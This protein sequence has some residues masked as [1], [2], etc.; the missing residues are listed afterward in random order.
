MYLSFP[1]SLR[2]RARQH[3]LRAKWHAENGDLD[4]AAG[5]LAKA[6]RWYAES[7]VFR[8]PRLRTGVAP[9]VE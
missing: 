7:R 9:H 1:E 5:S 6:A 2:E 3:L 8:L 4:Y